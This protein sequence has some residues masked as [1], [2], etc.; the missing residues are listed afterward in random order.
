MAQA[1]HEYNI[2]IDLEFTPLS[3][4][5]ATPD[6]H[7]EIIEIGAVRTDSKGTVIGS[8]ET[9]VKPECVEYIAPAITELTGIKTSDVT[10]APC[11]AEAL[12]QL[13]SWIGSNPSIRIVAWS[14]NDQRQIMQECTAKHVTVPSEL[15]CWLDLQRIF[16][17]MM[18]LQKGRRLVRLADALEWYGIKPEASRLHSALY[19]AEC[20]AALFKELASGDYKEHIK[21]LQTFMPTRTVYSDASDSEMGVM[22]GALSVLYQQMLSQCA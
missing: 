15:S 7:D 4:E 2:I 22:A 13:V 12:K 10:E 1:I 5:D 20:T 6:F 19:D 16:P 11:F 18:Q 3:P 9:Y 17:R 21:R 8:F 14:D